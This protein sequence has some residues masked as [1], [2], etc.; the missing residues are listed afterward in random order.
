MSCAIF[1]ML[2][3][4]RSFDSSGPHHQARSSN[5]AIFD[6]ILFDM[7]SNV[8]ATTFP[9]LYFKK[10]DLLGAEQ[11]TN[12]LTTRYSQLLRAALAQARLC[13]PQGLGRGEQYAANWKASSRQSRSTTISRPAG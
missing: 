12:F 4:M 10:P 3:G 11:P 2:D 8:V 6:E 13:L 1:A 9:L 7:K 5:Y